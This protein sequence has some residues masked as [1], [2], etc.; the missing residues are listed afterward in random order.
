[1][2]KNKK[3]LKFYATSLILDIQYGGDRHEP[4]M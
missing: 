1:M 4:E 3:P 2:Y